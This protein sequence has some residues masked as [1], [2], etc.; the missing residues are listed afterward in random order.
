VTPDHTEITEEMSLPFTCRAY[1]KK[2]VPVARRN[3]E[4]DGPWAGRTS[5]PP[6]T[7]LGDGAS[8]EALGGRNGGLRMKYINCE[9]SPAIAVKAQL[10]RGTTSTT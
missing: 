9:R 1:V 4:V 10:P 7:E 2:A 5:Y 6:T 3:A 8:E